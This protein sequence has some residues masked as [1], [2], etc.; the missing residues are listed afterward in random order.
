MATAT[1]TIRI[2][3]A[4]LGEATTE[5][6]PSYSTHPNVKL[7]AAADKRKYAL[8]R[9][10][11]EFGSEVY[12]DIEDMCKAP[13]LDAIYVATNHELHCE[14]VL[15]AL[16]CG[17]H[18]VVEKPMAL[19]VEECERMNR[20]AEEKGLILLC[21]H[22]HS[23]DAPIRKMR[24]IIVSGELGKVCMINTWN[25]NDFMVRPYPHSHLEF[26]RGVVLNQG[27]HQIDIVRLLGGGMVRSVRAMAGR[28]DP[29]RPG[30]G[31]YV[32][33]LEFEDGTPASLVF[34]GYGFFDTAELFW[35]IGEGGQARTQYKNQ[36]SRQN[37][38][39]LPPEPERTRILEEM[40]NR[41]RYGS[42]GVGEAPNMPPGW[43]KG[44]ARSHSGPRHQSFFGITIVTC[45]K[46]DMRQSQDG[47][48]IYGDEMREVPIEASAH[49]RRAEL[50]ELYNAIVHG[51]PLTHGG[52]W[53]QAT[54]EVCQALLQ[55]AAE[56]RE[57]MLE[58]QVPAAD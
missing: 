25:F 31:G 5:I 20:F 13:D 49:G 57:V 10:H 56:R 2:G 8:E 7:A 51:K 44:G 21:G 45:E 54:V 24:E 35:W 41:M 52:R 11:E 6:L 33:Y 27:P 32:C 47:V 22:N 30:E 29:S 15:M 17:K 53:G 50:D 19:T 28:W 1:D 18:V 16:D 23:W 55:S 48:L 12:S 34:N 39:S 58:H 37:Y 46:G 40:K 26:S 42:V 14:H 3:I 43:E 36:T 4:G 38:R 9:F